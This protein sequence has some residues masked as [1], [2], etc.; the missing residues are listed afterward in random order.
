MICNDMITNKDQINIFRQSIK[1]HKQDPQYEGDS[2]EDD[3][4]KH[5]NRYQY[6]AYNCLVSIVTKTQ[7]KIDVIINSLIYNSVK[8]S[9]ILEHIFNKNYEYK[10]EV[11]TDFSKGNIKTGMY[12]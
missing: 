2:S 11:I 9:S 10:F 12:T 6:S 4:I 3:H 7:I 1:F 5:F 8:W